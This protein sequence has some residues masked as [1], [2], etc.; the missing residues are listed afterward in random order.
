MTE[1]KAFLMRKQIRLLVLKYL[2]TLNYKGKG[3]V[4]IDGEKLMDECKIT[5]HQ[6]R[7]SLGDLCKGLSLYIQIHPDSFVAKWKIS[8]PS[9]KQVAAALDIAMTDGNCTS[10]N[11]EEV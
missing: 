5:P 4:V 9:L 10:W 2:L 11:P 1:N 6:M 3:L 7:R 8:E